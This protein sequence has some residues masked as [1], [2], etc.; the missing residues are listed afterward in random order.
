[1]SDINKN[2][3]WT[4]DL[5]A[6]LQAMGTTS[7]VGMLNQ[8]IGATNL[9]G[10]GTAAQA[11]LQPGRAGAG[12]RSVR[13][14][15]RRRQRHSWRRLV[16]FHEAVYDSLISQGHAKGLLDLWRDHHPLRRL[17]GYYTAAHEAVRQQVNTYIKSGVFDGVLDFD[18][19]VTD[20]GQSPQAAIAVRHLDLGGWVGGWIAP[21]PGGLP[22]D[23]G[24]G[25]PV[26]LHEVRRHNVRA[27]LGLT[28]AADRRASFA[29]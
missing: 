9:V 25:R 10:T 24:L 8:G 1:M 26:A 20:G 3:R 23:G 16:R 14:R 2:D 18:A 29:W 27:A 17:F 5:S 22:E 21:E 6:R 4:D 7:N 28:S 13:D 15:L 11:R 12:R 19:A